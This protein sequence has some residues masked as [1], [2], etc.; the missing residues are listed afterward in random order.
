MMSSVHESSSPTRQ[1]ITVVGRTECISLGPGNVPMFP[2]RVQQR[3][4]A[5]TGNHMEGLTRRGKTLGDSM[6]FSCINFSEV[7]A[8]MAIRQP[9]QPACMSSTQRC[10][11][12]RRQRSS[13]EM[14]EMRIYGFSISLNLCSAREFC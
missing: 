8:A 2:V 5:C 11:Y 7:R 1:R 13:I 4:R 9:R 6:R 14:Q 10:A 3:T 12:S